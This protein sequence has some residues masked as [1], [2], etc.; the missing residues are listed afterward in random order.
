MVKDL[1]ERDEAIKA[2]MTINNS[3][4]AYAAKAALEE[5]PSPILFNMKED[6]NDKRCTP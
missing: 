5:V 1:I 3:Y 6:T 2:V 4:W